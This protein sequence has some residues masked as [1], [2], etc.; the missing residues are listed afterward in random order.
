MTPRFGNA[1]IIHDLHK[2]SFRGLVGK[3]GPSK[4]VKEAGVG[5][6]ENNGNVNSISFLCVCVKEGTKKGVVGR[7]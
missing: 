3:E 5:R 4:S 7:E 1:E 2:C 6:K